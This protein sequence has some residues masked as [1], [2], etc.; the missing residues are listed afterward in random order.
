MGPRHLWGSCFQSAVTTP[1]PSTVTKRVKE[2]LSCKRANVEHWQ[3]AQ[4]SLSASIPELPIPE[5]LPPPPP[6]PTP[7]GGVVADSPIFVVRLP[8]SS[9]AHELCEPERALW[10]LGVS[11]FESVRWGWVRMIPFSGQASR[12]GC[13]WSSCSH[14]SFVGRKVL[15]TSRGVYH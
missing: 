7:V 8:S 14:L 13:R 15:A 11:V 10:P 9:D 3:H 6:A 4:R 12:R 5:A 1:C 2:R